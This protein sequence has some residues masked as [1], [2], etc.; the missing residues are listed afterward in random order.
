MQQGAVLSELT[1]AACKRCAPSVTAAQATS[2]A[3]GERHTAASGKKIARAP[4]TTAPRIARDA[5]A[6]VEA[7]SIPRALA[8]LA[9]LRATRRSAAS[10]GRS[11]VA[12]REASE[13]TMARHAMAAAV[14]TSIDT[15]KTPRWQKATQRAPNAC[16]GATC[17]TIEGAMHAVER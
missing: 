16:E 10:C 14:R 15:S 8:D 3:A 12:R 4:A 7:R 2:E 17:Q 1:P 13:E 6:T 5:S 11:S 9:S